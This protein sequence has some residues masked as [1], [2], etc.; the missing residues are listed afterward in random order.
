MKTHQEK[1]NVADLSLCSVQTIKNHRNFSTIKSP[2]NHLLTLT[3]AYEKKGS[4]EKR[5]VDGLSF[6]VLRIWLYNYHTVGWFLD[7]SLGSLYSNFPKDF[8][9][10][11]GSIGSRFHVQAYMFTCNVLLLILPLQASFVQAQGL[12][13]LLYTH[14]LGPISADIFTSICRISC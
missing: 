10:L 8:Q 6:S 7:V 1:F 13:I 4:L 5:W 9:I 11:T 12:H 2:K 14:F 3:M